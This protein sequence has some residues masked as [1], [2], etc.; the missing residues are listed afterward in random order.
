MDAL[1]TAFDL[2]GLTTNI[3]AALTIG[4]S[5]VLLFAGYRAIRKTGRQIV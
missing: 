4:V 3:T 2:D 1:F 5:V